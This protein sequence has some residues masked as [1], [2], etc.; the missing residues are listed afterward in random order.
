MKQAS[1]KERRECAIQRKCL[2]WRS[3]QRCAGCKWKGN[4]EADY[5]REEDA[6]GADNE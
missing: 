5:F 1:E 4:G 3:V 6:E 2:W